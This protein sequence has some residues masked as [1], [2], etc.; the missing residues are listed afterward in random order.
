MDSPDKLA[1]YG[2]QGEGKQNAICGRHH[3][4]QT[5]TNN[6]N[7]T[8]TLIQTTGGK[9]EPNTDYRRKSQS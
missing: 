9:D 3:Y 5:N 7:K 8:W 4:T 1:K 2:T 6:L